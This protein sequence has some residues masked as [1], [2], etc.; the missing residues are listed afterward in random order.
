MVG[1]EAPKDLQKALFTGSVG[2][3]FGGLL[4][5]VVKLLVEDHE[6][7][8]GAL[9]DQAE[10]TSNVLSDLKSVYDRVE[11]SRIVIAAHQSTST[12]GKEMRD[13]IDSRVQ[14]RNVIRALAGET[15]GF[16]DKRAGWLTTGVEAMETY[17]EALTD[18]FESNYLQAS[19]AQEV[20]E[21]EKNRL[22][23]GPK[24]DISKITNLDNEAWPNI[25]KKLR[26]KG[27]MR[28]H[29]EKGSPEA[30]KKGFEDPLDVA[31]WVL[32]DELRK[33]AGYR[34]S[35]IPDKYRKI[36]DR[37]ARADHGVA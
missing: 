3:I 8:R 23:K 34:E 2:L 4:T 12:Y 11:R 35:D 32:R 36:A 14:L 5:A 21:A 6:R 31:T 1:F 20:Y 27:F 25:V 15:R 24:E 10:F 18:A 16:G 17:L 26:E 30:Y 13:L 7:K 28:D 33:L 29:A 22:A 37:L 19:K 9:A